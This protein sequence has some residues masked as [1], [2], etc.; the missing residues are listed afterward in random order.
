M[1]CVEQDFVL[2]SYHSDT[3]YGE[4]ELNVELRGICPLN[5]PEDVLR[6]LSFDIATTGEGITALTKALQGGRLKMTLE[7]V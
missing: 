2:H 4:L 3:H 5:S 6:K 7:I 1:W